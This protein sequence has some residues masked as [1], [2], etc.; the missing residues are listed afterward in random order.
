MLINRK[1]KIK[2][3]IEDEV[4][5]I[6]EKMKTC[7]DPEEYKKLAEMLMKMQEINIKEKKENSEI[8]SRIFKVSE[9][10]ISLAGVVLPL[11]YYNHWVNT[12]YEFEKNGNYLSSS[13]FRGVLTKIKPNK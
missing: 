8:F 10:A 1:P 3:K 13:T 6:L 7:E 4:N 5:K 12:G 11:M 9:I 2:N